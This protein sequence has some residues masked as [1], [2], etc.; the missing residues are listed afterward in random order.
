VIDEL[1]EWTHK[2][3][4]FM[5]RYIEVSPA[6]R[7]LCFAPTE[8]KWKLILRQEASIDR[9]MERKTRLLWEMQEEDRKR[10][11]DPE[12]QEIEREEAEAAEAREAEARAQEA[13]QARMIEEAALQ[14]SE[15]IKKM[16]EQSRQ[17]TENTGGVP[18]EEQ[19]PGARNQE[20]RQDS[21][22]GIQ[23]S[24]VQNSEVYPDESRIHGPES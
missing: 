13:E 21:G 20:S 23:D 5:R 17:A 18:D 2:Y 3:Q 6:R 9:Q 1:I 19:E 16:R 10:R 7:D 24:G 22:F 14:I 8:A 11:K 12:W 15:N 4:T